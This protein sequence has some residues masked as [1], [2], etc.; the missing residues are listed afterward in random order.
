MGGKLIIE[1]IVGKGTVL[2]IE[3]L[4]SEVPNWFASKLYF[5][6]NSDLILLDDDQ[7]IHDVWQSRFSSEIPA[8]DLNLIHYYAPE[9]LINNEEKNDN[10]HYLIDYE[11]IGSAINGLDVIEMLDLGGKATLVTSRYDDELI[12]AKC[13]VLRAKILPKYY[14]PFVT[15]HV[16]YLNPDLILIDDN[17]DFTSSLQYKAEFSAKKLV[18][19]NSICEA[20]RYIGTYKRDSLIYVDSHLNHGMK[21]ELYAKVLFEMGFTNIHLYTGYESDVFDVA[22]MYWI[23]SIV[24][25]DTPLFN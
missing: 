22:Q 9:L 23:K 11:L 13:K 24:K 4:Q 18:V 5:F 12:Q 16:L 19:F 3:L 6:E 10:C 17:T 14:A 8:A 15:L 2:H 25:K 20:E 21:G 1:S 7:P